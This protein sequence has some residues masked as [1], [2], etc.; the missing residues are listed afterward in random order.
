M[1]EPVI[2]GYFG[3]ELPGGN[4]F[5]HSTAI[6]VNSGRN[7]L[8]FIFK[9]MPRLP[10]TV[11]IPYYTCEVL[12]QPMSK[13]GLHYEFFNINDRL[14]VDVWPKLGDDDYIIVNNYFGIKDDYIWKLGCDKSILPHL[15]IDA[16]QAWYSPEILSSHQFYSPRKF[17]GVPDGGVAFTPV[18]HDLP[19]QQGHSFQRCSHLLKRIDSGARSGYGDFQN[20]DKAL[21]YAPLTAMSKLTKTIL[22]GID[23]EEVKYR[24]RRNFEILHC[25]LAT[26]NRLN[27]PDMDT[28]QCPM[29]YPYWSEDT[30]LRS[31][32]IEQ[33]IFVAKYWPNVMEWCGNETLEYDFAQNLLPLPCDQRYGDKDMERIINCIKNDRK[34]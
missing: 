11:W 24:R 28:F 31:K 16:S 17:F 9:T 33:D 1:T 20:N 8:E 32:L 23:S 4:A 12:L 2:G 5:L 3:L 34:K 29:I 22:A 27:I 6:L 19:L 25:E 7:A 15:I 10:S 21:D 18:S 30:T 14:E 13:L 26:S